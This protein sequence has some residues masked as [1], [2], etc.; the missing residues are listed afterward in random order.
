MLL[1]PADFG[2]NYRL[3]SGASPDLQ[4]A[5]DQIERVLLSEFFEEDTKRFILADLTQ[6]PAT[7]LI[8]GT[9]ILSP[10]R[11]VAVP[12]VFGQM[13]LGV[14]SVGAQKSS[15][16]NVSQEI[17]WIT[18]MQST[19]R[20]AKYRQELERVARTDWVRELNVVSSSPLEMQADA[21]FAAWVRPG[22][23]LVVF[24]NGYMLNGEITAVSS[25]YVVSTNIVPSFTI[26]SGSVINVE[27]SYALRQKNISL[28]YG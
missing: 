16:K 20:I 26:P 1:T 18:W 7:T 23:K 10:W 13:T 17:G 14:A 8:A 24:A 25:T 21:G 12:C 15:Q 19:E 6:P 9:A 27:L 3:P 4:A 28:R 11:E 22:T 2:G 5:I